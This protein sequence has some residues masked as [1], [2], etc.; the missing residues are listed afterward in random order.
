MQEGNFEQGTKDPSTLS[1]P[2]MRIYSNTWYRAMF[3]P[4]IYSKA[5]QEYLKY[6]IDL[7]FQSYR[8]CYK[9]MEEAS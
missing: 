1:L 8:A 2:N 4:K 6:W 3:N 5:H 9:V 7:F